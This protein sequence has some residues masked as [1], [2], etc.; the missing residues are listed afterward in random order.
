M[1]YG[2]QSK[3]KELIKRFDS[4]I[5]EGKRQAKK[6]RRNVIMQTITISDS[7][8][9]APNLGGRVSGDINSTNFMIDVKTLNEILTAIL[10]EAARK[11]IPEKAELKAKMDELRKE[12]MGKSPNKG[13]IKE[14]LDWTHKLT[15]IPV[16]ISHLYRFIAPLMGFPPL[17]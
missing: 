8:V 16:A 12:V 7:V 5:A 14:I 13:K 2:F 10:E 4:E 15:A 11:N 9:I 3:A 17:P 1:L 6:E